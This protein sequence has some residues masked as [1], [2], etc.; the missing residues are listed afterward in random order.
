[1]ES[2]TQLVATLCPTGAKDG[3]TAPGGH[4]CTKAMLACTLEIVGLEGA[5]HRRLLEGDG[6]H[7]GRV[8]NMETRAVPR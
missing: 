8:V 1:M 2:C 7:E 3:T 5:L 4:A 6:L